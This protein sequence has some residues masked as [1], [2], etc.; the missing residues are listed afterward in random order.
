MLHPCK[1]NKFS[2]KSNFF[3]I[4]GI[5]NY[6]KSKNISH[7]DKDIGKKNSDRSLF[8]FNL[9]IQILNLIKLKL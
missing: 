3:L 1:K 6:L 7:M 9:F 4:T 5:I 8:K 2:K